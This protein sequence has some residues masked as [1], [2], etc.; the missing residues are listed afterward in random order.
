MSFTD[1]MVGLRASLDETKEKTTTAV[2]AN[3]R[4][5]HELLRKYA[6]TQKANAQQLR[7]DLERATQNLGRGVKEMREDNIRSQ[8]ELRSDFASAHKVFLGKQK[9]EEETQETE[10]KE[11]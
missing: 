6:Q 2:R 9:V 7:G 5:T 8:R 10:E 4:D 3:K 11:E 1:Q